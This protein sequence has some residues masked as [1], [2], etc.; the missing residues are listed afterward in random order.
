MENKIEEL[1]QHLKAIKEISKETGFFN[2]DSLKYEFSDKLIEEVSEINA[3]FRKLGVSDRFAVT[4][5]MVR[6]KE[7]FGIKY[8]DD[9][10]E[11]VKDDYLQT[12]VSIFRYVDKV[13]DNTKVNQC[14]VD[15]VEFK[16]TNGIPSRIERCYIV[17][18]CD[19]VRIEM[20]II[21]NKCHTSTYLILLNH[22]FLNIKFDMPEGLAFND[23][24]E[25]YDGWIEFEGEGNIWLHKKVND[26]ETDSKE[27]AEIINQKINKYIS[28]LD[29]T[30][31][32][33]KKWKEMI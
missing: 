8:N 1:K 27:V 29:D 5:D 25:R 32:N 20:S 4:A 19:N 16:K 2:P 23:N 13:M 6:H 14:R 33:M 10:I 28:I 12:M 18:K 9:F 24:M 26:F 7:V 11:E 31:N 15:Y 22:S 30:I 3:Y 21:N 17:L